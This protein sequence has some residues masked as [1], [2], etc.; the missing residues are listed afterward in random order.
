MGAMDPDLEREPPVYID[1]AFENLFGESGV[2]HFDLTGHVMASGFHTIQVG[3][4]VLAGPD[5]KIGTVISHDGPHLPVVV[6][7]D[8]GPYE[9]RYAPAEVGTFGIGD[10]VLVF[11]HFDHLPGQLGNI[12]WFVTKKQ[13][14]NPGIVSINVDLI[15]AGGSGIGRMN[16]DPYTGAVHYGSGLVR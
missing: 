12:I 5:V 7:A 2:C 14:T 16:V 9:C 4:M 15:G 10:P 11:E 6:A 13:L 1:A 8:G 3:G